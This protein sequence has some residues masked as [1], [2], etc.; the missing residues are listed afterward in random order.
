MQSVCLRRTKDVLLNLPEKVEHAV[1]VQHNSHW[2]QYSREL[3]ASF[4]R[5]FGR[6]RTS[7]KQWDGAEFFRQ[8]TMLRQFCNHPMFAREELPIQVS[9]RWQDSAKIVHLIDSLLAFVGGGREIQHPKAV[10]FSSFVGFL[11][12]IGHALEESHMEFTWLTGNLSVGQRDENLNKF[13][14][15]SH[16]HVLLAS[17]QAAGV[18]IDLRCAQNVYLMACSF[19]LFQT[20]KTR[21]SSTS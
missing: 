7:E 20:G 10:V 14:G 5:D 3:H 15:V 11:E 12:I 18:G 4:I 2:E 19:P 6:L 17:L 9:W 1:V 8:L 16:C 13:R 21:R